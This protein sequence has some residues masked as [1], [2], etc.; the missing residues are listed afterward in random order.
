MKNQVKKFDVTKFETLQTKGEVLKGGF[1]SAMSTSLSGG[2]IDSEL[3]GYCPT[4]NSGNCVA[5][6]GSSQSV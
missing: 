3:N 1:S 5:G 4:T 2:K 6:C